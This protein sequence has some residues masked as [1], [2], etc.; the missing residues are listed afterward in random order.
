MTS[1]LTVTLPAAISSSAC[2]REATPAAAINF[3]RRCSTV[4]LRSATQ[5]VE[6]LDTW[7]LRQILQP[8]LKQKLLRRSVHHRTSD[9]LF[10][11]FRHDQFFIQQRLDG[12]RRLHAAYLE[13]FRHGNR[14]P[15]GNHRERLE[16]RDREFC[17]G[18]R[19]EKRAHM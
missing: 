16:R 15:I 6:V 12:G 8:E 17:T 18:P 13:N 7:Q 3:C 11:S 4:I 2:L 10:A 14:L 19:F 9:S 1:P 5:I